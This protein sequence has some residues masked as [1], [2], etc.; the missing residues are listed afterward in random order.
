MDI[1][2]EVSHKLFNDELSFERINQLELIGRYVTGFG[3]AYLISGIVYGLYVKSWPIHGTLKSTFS[4]LLL[5]ILWLCIA[6]GLKVFVEGLIHNSSPERKFSAVRAILFKDMFAQGGLELENFSVLQDAVKNPDSAKFVT[7][8]IPSLT[9]VS[10]D[11]NQKVAKHTN[12]ILATYKDDFQANSYIAEIKPIRQSLKIY[13]DNEFDLY[14]KYSTA[15]KRQLKNTTADS[16]QA[17]ANRVLIAAKNKENEIW[18]L[19][20]RDLDNRQD[21]V[22][23]VHTNQDFIVKYRTIYQKKKCFKAKHMKAQRCALFSKHG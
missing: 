4:L 12:L 17:N 7:A 22:N 2:G 9:Y 23:Y 6:S 11:I 5:F 10:D 21:W 1:Y 8:L 13:A 15:Y 16:I 18:Q 19:L 14:D 3:L 20:Q